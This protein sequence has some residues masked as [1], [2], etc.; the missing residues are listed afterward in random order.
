MAAPLC[1]HL[2][3][4]GVPPWHCGQQGVTL[5]HLCLWSTVL[6]THSLT[7]TAQKLHFLPTNICTLLSVVQGWELLSVPSDQRRCDPCKL[8]AYSFHLQGVYK[9]AP[10]VYTNTPVDTNKCSASANLRL[11]V[12]NNVLRWIILSLPIVKTCYT[13]LSS[14]ITGV[15]LFCWLLQCQH[16]HYHSDWK[17]D[18]KGQVGGHHWRAAEGNQV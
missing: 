9:F 1:H 7:L 6:T 16:G 17:W 13:H 14:S 2:W 12:L 15:L 3:L 8:Q 11:S 4:Q 18:R 5:R 10:F